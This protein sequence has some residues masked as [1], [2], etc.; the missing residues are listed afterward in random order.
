MAYEIKPGQGTLFKND[1]YEAGGIQPY[2][3]GKV[4]TPDGKEWEAALWIPKSDKVKGFNVSI[5]EPY[6]KDNT[7]DPYVSG[8][9]YA[10]NTKET[11]SDLPF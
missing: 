11:G 4:K 8:S 6:V 5:K 7:D 2:C 1:K 10:D 9:P 3:R